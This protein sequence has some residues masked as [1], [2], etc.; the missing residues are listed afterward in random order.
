GVHDRVGVRVLGVDGA[1][2]VDGR[3]QELVVAAA[4][5]RGRVGDNNNLL[6]ARGG[7]LGVVVVDVALFL[8]AGRGAA[9]G[10]QHA[11][12]HGGGQPG[13]RDGRTCVHGRIYL[14]RSETQAGRGICATPESGVIVK[15]GAGPVNERIGQ[16]FFSP[17]LGGRGERG[18]PRGPASRNPNRAT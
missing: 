11:D 2:Q 10:Q 15:G 16:H 1:R 4:A 8:A 3:G 18:M 17:P 7:L 13:A 12:D 9:R 6:D 14:K 5:V